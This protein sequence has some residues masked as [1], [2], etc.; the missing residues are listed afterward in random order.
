METIYGIDNYKSKNKPFYLALGNFDGIHIGHKKLITAAINKAKDNNGRSGAFIF[1]P[2]P[3]QVLMPDKAPLLLVSSERKADLLE[4]LGLDALIYNNFNKEIARCSP[5]EFVQEIL[6]KKLKVDEVFVG[7]NHSFGYKGKGT[8]ELLKQLGKKYGFKVTIIEAVKI[9]EQIVSSSLIRK[10]LNEGNIN[11]AY[12]ML[13]YYPSIDGIVVEGENRGGTRLGFP[14]AN[15]EVNSTY[16]V[17]GKG[18]Y[19]A[20]ALVNGAFY[21]SMVNIGIKPTFHEEYPVSIE[22]HLMNFNDS[23]YDEHITLLFIEKLRVEQRF[24]DIE[25]L[26]KQITADKNQAKQILSSVNIE[27]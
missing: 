21:D 24:T 14:T 26:I 5:E 15:V 1:E 23:I 25:E 16:M 11:S 10:V 8:P 27:V 19:A 4:K 13:G 12:E 2:H 20:K 3:A 6:V 22:A 17:P 9:G 18:V 7:F